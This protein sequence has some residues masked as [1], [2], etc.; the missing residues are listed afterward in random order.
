MVLLNGASGSFS[1]R[2][3]VLV[4]VTEKRYTYVSGTLSAQNADSG[5]GKTVE[6]D[7]GMRQDQGLQRA[8][9][10]KVPGQK[11]PSSRGPIRKSHSHAHA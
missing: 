2:L 6:K 3:R 11:L 4:P 7:W 1:L 9:F 8:S 10:K 5:Y